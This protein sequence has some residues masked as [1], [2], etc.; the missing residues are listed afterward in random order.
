MTKTSLLLVPKRPARTANPRA[1]VACATPRCM[2]PLV[3]LENIWY[4]PEHK[5]PESKFL[6][7]TT[8]GP[9]EAAQV[10]N[11]TFLEEGEAVVVNQ[12][13]LQHQELLVA[14]VLVGCGPRAR[15]HAVDV[16]ATPQRV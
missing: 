12:L 10:F 2:A 15:V 11:N 1:R 9:V 6:A 16:E 4:N 13:A 7:Q 3:F 5:W 14:G 8:L